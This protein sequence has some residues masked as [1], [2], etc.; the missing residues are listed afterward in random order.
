MK[1]TKRYNTRRP[2]VQLTALWGNDDASGTI[3]ISRRRWRSI[4][5]GAVFSKSG[6]SWYEGSRKSVTWHFSGGS[7]SISDEDGRQNVL[8][9]SVDNLH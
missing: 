8:D 9:L 3:K 4:Q 2:Y 7:V 6:W 5:E 1:K